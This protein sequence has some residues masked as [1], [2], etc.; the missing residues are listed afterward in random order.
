MNLHQT[1]GAVKRNSSRC[2]SSSINASGSASFPRAALARQL[3]SSCFKQYR[4]VITL[5]RQDR[6]RIGGGFDLHHAML[7]IERLR[8]AVED[9]SLERKFRCRINGITRQH[10]GR[11]RGRFAARSAVNRTRTSRRSEF[12]AETGTNGADRSRSR[13][14]RRRIPCHRS[15]PVAAPRSPAHDPLYPPLP[16][17]PPS[18]LP[19]GCHLRRR[20]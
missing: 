18:W 16:G 2:P 12:S 7:A 11:G 15:F 9:I 6:D 14:R 5:R 13:P 17:D 19:P 1:G 3:S 4:V 8:A 20:R 10:T